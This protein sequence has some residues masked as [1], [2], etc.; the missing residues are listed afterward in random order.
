MPWSKY[1]LF[2]GK[3]EIQTK[4]L[5]LKDKHTAHRAQICQNGR[6]PLR[7]DSR[8]SIPQTKRPL[9]HCE[10]FHSYTKK[11]EIKLFLL[12]SSY[13]ISIRKLHSLITCNQIE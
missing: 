11:K 2:H 13:N 6:T 3:M 9:Q 5:S 12:R 4:I 8:Y 7:N 10:H 1:R